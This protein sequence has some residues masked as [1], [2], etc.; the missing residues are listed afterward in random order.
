TA[1]WTSL[2]LGGHK[3][4][5]TPGIP[6]ITGGVLSILIGAVAAGLLT[7]PALSVHLPET[8]GFTP[9][10]V[11]VTGGEQKSIPD[12]LSAPVNDTVTFVLFQPFAS[13]GGDRCAVAVGRILSILTFAVA[14]LLTLPALS[15]HV[16]DTG[17]PSPSVVSVTGGVQESMPERSSVPVVET[18]TLPL[19][20][21]LPFGAGD[22]T[23][24]AVGGVLSG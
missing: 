11:T 22:R 1:T 13:G 17:W 18:F 6:E 10:V 7:L 4:Q 16:P 12:R 21:P 9:S 5:P 2:L 14:G 23:S 15:V 3:K 24:V 8:G 20:H 19:F